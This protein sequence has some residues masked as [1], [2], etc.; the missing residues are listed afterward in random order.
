MAPDGRGIAEELAPVLDGAVRQQRRRAF[1]PAH[2]DR[3]TGG[4][5]V[6]R[7]ERGQMATEDQGTSRTDELSW[8]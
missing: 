5:G 1:V 2:H 6:K 8:A 4:G 3:V 7:R